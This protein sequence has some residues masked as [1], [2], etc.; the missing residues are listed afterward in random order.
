MRTPPPAYYQMRSAYANWFYKLP[1][2]L[3]A[4]ALA[5]LIGKRSGLAGLLRS[6]LLAAGVAVLLDSVKDRAVYESS[7][8]I[9][10]STPDTM[11]EAQPA[12]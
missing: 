3:L 12:A 8:S 4:I 2:S 5:M 7:R 10:E 1:S 11:P 9:Y 6:V